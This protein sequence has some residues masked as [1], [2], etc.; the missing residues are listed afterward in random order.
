MRYV[1]TIFWSFLLCQVLAYIAGSM[2]GAGFDL[3][4]NTI[5]SFFFAVIV[6]FVGEFS[7]DDSEAKPHAH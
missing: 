6:F 2:L 4:L 1:F 5:L 3:R 7:I